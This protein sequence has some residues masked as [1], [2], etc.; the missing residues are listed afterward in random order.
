MQDISFVDLR[1][2]RGGQS[3]VH[4]GFRRLLKNE[5]TDFGMATNMSGTRMG[6]GRSGR[7]PMRVSWN[8]H[9]PTKIGT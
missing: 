7:A 1:I 4:I 2:R 3:D 5:G 9:I 8:D 6:E